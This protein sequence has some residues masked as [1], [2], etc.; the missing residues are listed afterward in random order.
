MWQFV[1]FYGQLKHYQMNRI[2]VLQSK[3]AI[4]LNNVT[5]WKYYHLDN[6][7]KESCFS[8]NS[9]KRTNNLS[10]TFTNG[11][12]KKRP[13]NDV[14]VFQNSKVF[15]PF[16]QNQRWTWKHDAVWTLPN[17]TQLYMYNA[18]P[19]IGMYTN[20]RI[21]LHMN[22]FIKILSKYIYYTWY[23]E[24]KIPDM[25][26]LFWRTGNKIHPVY[27]FQIYLTKF[28]AY[29]ITCI[30]KCLSFVVLTYIYY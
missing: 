23:S 12:Q 30:S 3:D 18:S 13:L 25:C 28:Q 9:Y 26:S 11:R 29:N 21:S 19:F 7:F 1:H 10:P 16:S 17:F 20:W 8:C 5:L 15:K 24:W 22:K 2:C 14:L 6:Q 27:L 4:W